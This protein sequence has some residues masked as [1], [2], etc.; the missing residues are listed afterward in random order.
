MGSLGMS[1]TCRYTRFR[2][3][4]LASEPPKAIVWPF[5][6]MVSFL[7][8]WAESLSALATDDRFDKCTYWGIMKSLFCFEDTNSKS[9]PTNHQG[10]CGLPAHWNFS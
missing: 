1:W 9:K 6:E 5:L 4:S 7:D 10:E 3:T 8:S 2:N